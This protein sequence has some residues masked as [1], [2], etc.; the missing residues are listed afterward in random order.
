[1][2]FAKVHGL[3]NDF[4]LINNLK[5]KIPE[6][7]MGPLAL[8]LCRQHFSIGGDGIILACEPTDPQYDIRFR[9][10][11]NDGSEAQMCG[12]GIRCFAKFA[13]EQGIIQKSKMNIETLA[14][15]IIPELNLQDGEVKS[16]TVDMGE[17]IIN[18]SEVPVKPPD[19]NA[20]IFQ[21]QPVK[22]KDRT[23]HVTAVSM[24]NPHAV[25]FLDESTNL[26]GEE[27]REFVNEYGSTLERNISLFP[28]K[29][30][31]E[32]VK[33]LSPKEGRMRVFERGVGITLACGTG[34]CASVVAGTL[35]GK[36]QK[37]TP[38][39]IHLDGGDLLITV[40]GKRVFM[41]GPAVEVFTG[42]IN[43]LEI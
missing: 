18:P 27:G 37:D 41:E 12:N 2:E 39:R 17:Y 29:V 28:E 3:G 26:E 36:F 9:I 4:I 19:P 30:N 24:G 10:F 43:N 32:F 21:D 15:P 7:K 6:E 16:V 11:N 40:S 25:I 42:I 8:N 38:V 20:T 13:Y 14:G 22:V 5:Y 34:T 23:F 31:V 33:V 1:M 35:L